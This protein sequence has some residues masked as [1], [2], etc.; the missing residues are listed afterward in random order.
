MKAFNYILLASGLAFFTIHISAQA[1]ATTSPST[2]KVQTTANANAMA[3]QLTAGV[4]QTVTGVSPAQ[5]S[6]I[7]AAEQDYSTGVLGVRD[8][9]SAD[10]MARYNKL[11]SL[12][13]TRDSQIK[14]ILTTDQYAQY[15]K[16][17]LGAY[18][19][20]PSAAGTGK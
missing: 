12:R 20:P 17:Q 9:K 11:E 19:M 5:E 6:K 15:Q 3:K 7:L 4:K 13:T 16:T 8:D 1:P 14:T 18:N 10:K 2:G